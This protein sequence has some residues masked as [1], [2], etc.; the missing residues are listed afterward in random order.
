MSDLHPKDYRIL[1][2]AAGL[3]GEALAGRMMALGMRAHSTIRQSATRGLRSTRDA[4]LA[5]LQLPKM[6]QSLSRVTVII[7]LGGALSNMVEAGVDPFDLRDTLLR[8]GSRKLRGPTKAGHY[9]RYVPFRHGLPGSDGR[10]G[11]PMGSQVSDDGRGSLSRSFRG[12][13]DAKAAKVLGRKIAGAAR[14]LDPTL[15]TADPK[16]KVKYG[17]GLGEGEGPKLRGRHATDIWA[18]MY[19]KLK[20][21][22]VAGVSRPA[23]YQYITF[24]TI[25]TNPGSDRYDE[26]QGHRTKNWTHPG[27]TERDFFGKAHADVGAW[28][29]D[30]SW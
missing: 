13:L 5:G 28:L 10:A 1:V 14:K 7:E 11:A 24:R 9:Y 20:V 22:E 6:E 12:A 23:G 8:P 2:D 18:G 25:S 19:R 21:Y 4:Y 3:H 29:L 27:I 16:R 17:E 15:S 30:G 26:D